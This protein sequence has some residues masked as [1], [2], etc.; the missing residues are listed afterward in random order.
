MKESIPTNV[1]PPTAAPTPPM[2]DLKSDC[3]TKE[4]GE[5]P[6]EVENDEKEPGSTRSLDSEITTL[7]SH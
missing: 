7:T 5:A 2:P 1:P 3:R 6:M 4:K